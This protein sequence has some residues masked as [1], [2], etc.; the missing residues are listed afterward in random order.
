MVFIHAESLQL[1][2]AA[3]RSAFAVFLSVLGLLER[4]LRNGTVLIKIFCTRR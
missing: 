3:A 4:A 1:L 2:F